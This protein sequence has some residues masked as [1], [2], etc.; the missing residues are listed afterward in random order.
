MKY[1]GIMSVPIN[2]SV[3]ENTAQI[4]QETAKYLYQQKRIR[5]P[6]LYSIS[7]LILTDYARKLSQKG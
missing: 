1:G 6:T 7:Q 3:S 5:K 4:L 2:T